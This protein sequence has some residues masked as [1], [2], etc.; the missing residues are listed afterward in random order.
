[1]RNLKGINHLKDLGVKTD[2]E[3]VGHETVDR[4]HLAQDGNQ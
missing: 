1:M 4:I 3:K 2:V